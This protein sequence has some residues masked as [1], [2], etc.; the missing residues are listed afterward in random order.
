MSNQEASFLHLPQ[1]HSQRARGCGWKEKNLDFARKQFQ[2]PQ[3]VNYKPMS[4]AS[5]ALSESNGQDRPVY[6]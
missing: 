6:K 5:P 1:D 3:A 2:Y 4:L